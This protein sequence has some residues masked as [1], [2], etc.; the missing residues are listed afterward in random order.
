[1]GERHLWPMLPALLLV[2]CGGSLRPTLIEA[3]HGKPS[4]VAMFFAVDDSDG[5]PVANLL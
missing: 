3:A 4:N 5:E 1:M 2:A